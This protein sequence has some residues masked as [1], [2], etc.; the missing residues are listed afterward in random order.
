MRPPSR[1]ARADSQAD[2]G[3]SGGF[4]RS[5]QE[6]REWWGAHDWS[7][8]RQ[9]DS[10]AAW[11][12]TCS[13]RLQRAALGLA[14]YVDGTRVSSLAALIEDGCRSWLLKIATRTIDWQ[15]GAFQFVSA[16]RRTRCPRR[17]APLLGDAGA[18][19]GRRR[20]RLFV[21]GPGVAAHAAAC[22]RLTPDHDAAR[23]PSMV[24]ARVS[25]VGDLVNPYVR[26]DGNGYYAWPG[27][28]G[29]RSRFRFRIQYGDPIACSAT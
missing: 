18:A 6:L 24:R 4:S 3:G 27:V 14:L 7:S 21:L 19:D 1:L 13:R 16:D 10:S 28:A 15:S 22:G 23:R 9:V 26:G 29:A 20:R 25:G 2:G 8:R 17:S 5:D 11:R 12:P